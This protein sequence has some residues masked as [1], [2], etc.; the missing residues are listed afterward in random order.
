MG[1]RILVCVAVLL[2]SGCGKR[3]SGCATPATQ[4]SLLAFVNSEVRQKLRLAEFDPI[5]S[6]LLKISRIEGFEATR[7]DEKRERS[8][9]RAIIQFDV[10]GSLMPTSVDYDLLPSGADDDSDYDTVVSME[11]PLGAI[12]TRLNSG[13][14]KRLRDKEH[15]VGNLEKLVERI[16]KVVAAGGALDDPGPFA[17]QSIYDLD[18]RKEELSKAKEDAAQIRDSLLAGRGGR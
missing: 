8:S 3:E 9:C 15:E 18:K 5:D 6:G 1:L 16:G 10:E 4:A 7:L 12:A 14:V 11:L 17:A 13:T 2:L